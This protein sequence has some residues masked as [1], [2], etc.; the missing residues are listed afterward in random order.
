[1]HAMHTE[2]IPTHKKKNFS[3]PRETPTCEE[4]SIFSNLERDAESNIYFQ[5]RYRRIENGRF[6]A[7]LGR[8]K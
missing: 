5:I 8:T 4:P 1:M 3:T 2:G 6:I 7:A